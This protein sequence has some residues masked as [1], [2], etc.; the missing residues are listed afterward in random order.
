M[1]DD[2]IEIDKDL[3]VEAMEDAKND[4]IFECQKALTLID[5]V[6]RKVKLSLP[7]F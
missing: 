1:D 3:I 5:E 7:F 4:F 6:R 2:E